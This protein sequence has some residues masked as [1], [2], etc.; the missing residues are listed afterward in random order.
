MVEPKRLLG[1]TSHTPNGIRT[2]AAGVKGRSPRPLDD[3]G[4][5]RS[6]VVRA[7]TRQG[8]AV[9]K[10]S[11]LV[12]GGGTHVRGGASPPATVALEPERISLL[13]AAA[14]WQLTMPS[15][16]RPDRAIGALTS[17]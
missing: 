16:R 14:E 6:V 4:S 13:K 9:G 17:S 10:A 8:G 7:G 12:D 11:N 1:K 2:R 5:K 3:G 15:T